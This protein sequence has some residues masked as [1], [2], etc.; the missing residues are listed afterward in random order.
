MLALSL[1]MFFGNANNIELPSSFDELTMGTYFL[2]GS[3]YFHKRQENDFLG[4]ASKRS[5]FANFSIA[6]DMEF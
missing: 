5:F 6:S 1:F 2:D 3:S 4:H